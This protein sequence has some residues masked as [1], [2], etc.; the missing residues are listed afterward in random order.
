MLLYMDLSKGR[1]IIIT[2]FFLG[3]GVP[4]F[5]YGAFWD[6]KPHPDF[7]TSRWYILCDKIYIERH[8]LFPPSIH[9][10]IALSS[11]TVLMGI[12]KQVKNKKFSRR[13][14]FQLRAEK[15][16]RLLFP[17]PDDLSFDFT[18]P[19][20]LYHFKCAAQIY[21]IRKKNIDLYT[22]VYCWLYVFWYLWYCV[23]LWISVDRSYPGIVQSSSFQS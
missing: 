14:L 23:L 19:C 5:P 13:T 20:F 9:I 18:A 11:S 4:L 6:V 22:L 1:V 3:G 17:S 8:R 21:Q 16:Y 2:S 7:S 10:F 15:D 12:D